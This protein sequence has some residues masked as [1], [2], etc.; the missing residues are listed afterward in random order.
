MHTAAYTIVLPIATGIVA[1][2]GV[3]NSDDGPDF[4]GDQSIGS[5]SPARYHT[6]ELLAWRGFRA[7]SNLPPIVGP[8]S[9]FVATDIERTQKGLTTLTRTRSGYGVKATRRAVR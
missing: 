8:L 6:S 7:C 5:R 9:M 3:S 2:R 1:S 4:D